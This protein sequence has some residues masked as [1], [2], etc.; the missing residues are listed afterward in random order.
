MSHRNSLHKSPMISVVTWSPSMLFLLLVITIILANKWQNKPLGL[1]VW[2]VLGLR[3]DYYVFPS[4]K[5]NCVLMYPLP[6]LSCRERGLSGS[7]KA[8]TN[9]STLPRARRLQKMSWGVLSVIEIWCSWKGV[10][11]QSG[12][13]SGLVYSAERRD[14]GG[15]GGELPLI[16][17]QERS[18]LGP[19]H[20]G[21][22]PWPFP[23]KGTS[24]TRKFWFMFSF[25]LIPENVC[26]A[27]C[28]FV[29]L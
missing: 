24:T 11:C 7:V 26:I 4:T 14:L 21:A 2:A 17:P 8:H 20:L 5:S 23:P 27:I 16:T 10:A 13:A 1:S 28:S 9:A 19:Q 15:W 3:K 18:I 22:T 25:P 29:V 12:E 6:S